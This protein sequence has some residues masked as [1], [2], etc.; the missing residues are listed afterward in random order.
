MMVSAVW[1]KVMT[2]S[3]LKFN[4]VKC[5]VTLDSS[6]TKAMKDYSNTKNIKHFRL[7]KD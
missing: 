1:L 4:E 7:D 6:S 3:W 5:L 2:K